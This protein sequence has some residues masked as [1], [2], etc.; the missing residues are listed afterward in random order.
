MPNTNASLNTFVNVWAY[1]RSGG[2]RL[3]HVAIV[4]TLFIP[5]PPTLE[6]FHRQKWK[7]VHTR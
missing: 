7:C 6:T 4:E 3:A 2:V 5:P 1:Y